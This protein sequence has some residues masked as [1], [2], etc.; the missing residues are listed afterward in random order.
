MK[1]KKTSNSPAG[2]EIPLEKLYTD[3]QRKAMIE[4]R[5]EIIKRCAL[6]LK[7]SDFFK[8]CMSLELIQ[9]EL[10]DGI[11]HGVYWNIAEEVY[12]K[13]REEREHS[14]IE[15]IAEYYGVKKGNP[16]E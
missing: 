14:V 8:L 10:R 2:Y 9:R 15:T 5:C 4:E 1:Q 3:E 12:M 7:A 6:L 16:K 11:L 13:Q